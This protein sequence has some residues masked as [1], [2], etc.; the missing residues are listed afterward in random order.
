[1]SLGPLGYINYSLSLYFTN[2]RHKPNK[3]THNTKWL[4]PETLHGKG[5]MNNNYIATI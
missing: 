4:I 3:Y 5:A 1:M 2:V